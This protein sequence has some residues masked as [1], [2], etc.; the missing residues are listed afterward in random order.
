MEVLGTL[1]QW[2]MNLASPL[3][4]LEMGI[5]VAAVVL[6][7]FI[8]R[9]IAM[10]FRRELVIREASQR[11]RRWGESA[12]VVLPWALAVVV[13]Q[14]TTLALRELILGQWMSIGLTVLWSVLIYLSGAQLLRLALPLSSA[15]YYERVFL[16]PFVLLIAVLYAVGWLPHIATVVR[17][18]LFTISGAQL[19][20]ASL[21][22]GGI[23]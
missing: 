12:M 8:G 15:R 3:A 14:V 19:S 20:I 5:L 16:L 2:L 6:S 17:K 7:L 10:H 1:K 13:V 23:A 11:T 18:P 4:L 22:K 9:L 21:V